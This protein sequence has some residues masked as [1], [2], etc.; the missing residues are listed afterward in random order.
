LRVAIAT[1]QVPFV[2]GGAEILAEGLRDA[3]AR[4]GHQAEI[5]AVP[6]QWNPPARILDHILASRLL[7]L[8][9]SSGVAIDRVIGLK[10]PAYLVPHPNKVLWIIHQHRSAYELWEHSLGDLIRYPDGALVRDAI[11]QADRRLVPEARRV[12]GISATVTR[13]LAHYCG[14]AARPL[15]HPPPGAEHLHA[16]EPEPYYFF[17]SRLWPT[18]RQTLVIDAL[19]FTRGA[20]AV[21]FAGVGDDPDYAETLARRAGD[22][23]VADRV[24]WLGSI[25]ADELRRQYATALAVVYPPADEDY[26]YVTLEAMLAAKAVITCSDSG[27]PLE[28]VAHGET[29]LVVEPEA[30]DLARA[31]DELWHDRGRARRLGRAARERYATL[32]ISWPRV[33]EEL[34][35]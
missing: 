33:V 34:L 28:F 16:G 2:R 20:V 13:R 15:Y 1:V 26:G 24:T 23:G 11:H 32:D 21:R 27:G 6:F 29:G 25:S 31:L 9:Q 4:A 19:R 17:P 35:A 30:Q 14:I 10:F 8:E 18:K 7:D 22:L 3:I 5:V 12:Y